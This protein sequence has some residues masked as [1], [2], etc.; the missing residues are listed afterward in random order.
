MAMNIVATNTWNI[1]VRNVVKIEWFYSK[2]QILNT[3]QPIPQNTQ[4]LDAKP[5]SH[6][7]HPNDFK[8]IMHSL[9]FYS[10][11]SSTK[12]VRFQ[13]FDRDCKNNE[14]TYLSDTAYNDVTNLR[15]VP[16]KRFSY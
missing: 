7:E 16:N 2:S 13:T 6:P 14:C 15:F 10:G 11:F 4:N 5:T 3:E 12:I 8:L 9:G 1:Y